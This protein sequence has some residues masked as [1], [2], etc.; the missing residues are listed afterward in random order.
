MQACNRPNPD[1]KIDNNETPTEYNN[2]TTD[3]GKDTLGAGDAKGS[4]HTEDIPKS[5]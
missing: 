5:E 3:I 4:D 1:K 2:D